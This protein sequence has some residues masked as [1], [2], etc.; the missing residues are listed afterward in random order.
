VLSRYWNFLIRYD[1]L[2]MLIF[3]T[4]FNQFYQNPPYDM[5]IIITPINRC[6]FCLPVK[7]GQK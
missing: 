7:L 3:V 5:Q 2:K 6:V 1:T 4:I